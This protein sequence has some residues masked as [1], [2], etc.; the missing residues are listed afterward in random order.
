[1]RKIISLYCLLLLV[2]ATLFA[3]TLKSPEAF[4][5]YKLGDYF[6]YHHKAVA[7][8]EHVAAAKASQVKLQYYGE[9]NEKRP[10]LLAFVSSERNMAKLEEIRTDNLKRAGVLEGKPVGAEIPIV[11][12]SYNVHG[13]ESVSMESAMMTL[14]D[15][16]SDPA[17]KDWLEK[18]VVAFDPCLNPDGRDRYAN[19]Y[20]QKVNKLLQPDINSVEHREPWPG[21]RANHY[22]F[23]LNRDWAWQTQVESRQRGVIYNQWLPHI[24]VDFHE[25]AINNPYYFAPAAE[26]FHEMITPWQREFQTTI[27]KNNAKYFDKEGWF[28]FT[29]ESFDLLYPSYGDT[30]PTYLGAIGMT[31]EKGGSG[32]AGLGVYTNEGDTLS[33]L[34]RIT[35]HHTTGISTI[36]ITAQNAVK[37]VEEFEKFFNRS[38]NNPWGK[39]KSYVIP[40]DQDPERLMALT[41]LLD[42][43]GIEYGHPAANSKPFSGYAY[44]SQKTDNFTLSEKDIVISA[45][46]PKSVLVNVLFDPNVKLSDSLTYDITAWALP[47]VYGLRARATNERINPV[48]P[49]EAPAYTSPNIQGKPYAYLLPWKSLSDAKY[50]SEL[51]KAGVKLRISTEPF[52]LDGKSYERGTLIITRRNNENLGDKFDQL[53]VEHAKALKRNV[54]PAFTGFVDSGKDFGSSSVRYAKAPKVGVV[55]GQGSSSLSFGEVWYFFEQDINYP[56][57][58][59]GTDYLAGVDLSA[60]DVLIFPSGNYGSMLNDN[61]MGKIKTWIQG[62]GKLI[63]IDGALSNFVD[64]EGFGLKRFADDAEKKKAEDLAKERAKDNRLTP[65]ADR[66]RAS[67]SNLNEGT[68]WLTHMDNTHPLAFGYS[69]RY[70]SLKNS[71][72]RYAWLNNGVN[73]G[74]IK[75]QNDLVSG[76]IG[77]NAK[78]NM[79]EALNFGVENMGRGT[80]VYFADNVLFRAFWH[81]GKLLFSNAVFMVG[82]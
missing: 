78:Q 72:Q 71:N 51:H 46:Q 4:L 13:N 75:N 63:L 56:V 52:T 64:K 69:P 53:V 34:D 77:A 18:V 15:I 23:D 26:P 54:T 67:A 81:D 59:L 48:K 2:P 62:G 16:L 43:H 21:G 40:G 38:K 29:K 36:E 19:W 20:N 61:M 49:F 32:S 68:I 8:Y 70:Y 39:Y 28:Y 30:Y 37:V 65:F 7:Y 27:G 5:G 10:L 80:V 76:F 1:M 22:L 25:Q 47:Y 3:Q 33:L 82:N 41:H 45:Y 17:K 55:S 12:L 79:R 6:T 57:S 58:I 66:R 74:V 50:L 44:L 9:T 73:V 14:Y 35:H 42:L 60:Y 11:W 24:H 31:Y